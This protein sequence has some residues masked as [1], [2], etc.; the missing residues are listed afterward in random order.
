MLKQI[1][2]FVAIEASASA[3]LY[4]ECV[5]LAFAEFVEQHVTRIKNLIHLFPED[6]TV[7]DKVTG[8][9]KG[10]FWTGHKKFPRVPELDLDD[11]LTSDYL[12][13]QSQLWAFALNVA[14]D[15]QPKDKAEFVAKAKA[16]NLAL[17]EW[18]EPIGL[19]IKVEEDEDE[20][21]EEKG[22]G[23]DKEEEMAELL[24]KLLAPA[25][26]HSS[27]PTTSSAARPSLL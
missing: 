21:E 7:K 8:E 27:P 4:D 18:T 24:K 11:D 5:K 3:S 17:P 9:V 2:A 20:D 10:L 19:K 16:L 13:A 12:Y 26:S 23:D 22:G 25:P 14:A 6:E 1:E 15:A